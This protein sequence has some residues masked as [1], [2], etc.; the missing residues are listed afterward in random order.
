MTELQAIKAAVDAVRPALRRRRDDGAGRDQ[1]RRRVQPPRRRHRRRADASST[2]TRAAARRCRSS[3]SSACRSR[4]SAA[5][6]ASRTS[7]RSTPTAWCRGC[8]AWA[9]CCRSSR[10]PSRRSTSRT[11]QRLEEKIRHDDFTLEDFRDQL[12]TLRKMG[13]LESIL[14]MMPGHGRTSSSWPSNKPDERQLVRVEAIINS[15]T[16]AERRRLP[17]DQ[18]Q[19]PQADR[20]RQRD[21]GRGDQPAAEAVRADAE[22]AEGRSAGWRAGGKGALKRLPRGWGSSS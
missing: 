19:P 6:S 7:S 15:M 21:V 14:G 18:R 17:A 8:S 16:P 9:T 12:R 13:P 1:E 22:D 2:A 10:R 11:R 3:R 5:A 20:A 4:S